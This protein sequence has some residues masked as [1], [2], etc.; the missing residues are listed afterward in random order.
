MV[1]PITFRLCLDRV[2]ALSEARFGEK[3]RVGRAL[4]RAF[5]KAVR[6]KPPVGAADAGGPYANSMEGR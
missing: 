3:V 1:N 2:S 4:R 6:T 5:D